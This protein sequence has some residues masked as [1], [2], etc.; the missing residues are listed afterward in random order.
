M[1]LGRAGL[2]GCLARRRIQERR[3]PCHPGFGRADRLSGYRGDHRGD[4]RSEG[5]NPP[6]T[7]GHRARQ[8]YRDG[9]C[10]GG[11]GGGAAARREGARRGRDLQSRLGRPAGADLRACRLGARRG[12][13]GRIGREGHALSPDLPSIDARYRVGQF[14]PAARGRRQ[15]RHESKNVQ[16]VH[17]RDEVRHRD[18]RGMQRHRADAAAGRALVPAV[19]GLRPCEGVQAAGLRRQ[20]CDHRHDRS[21][22][23]AAS[24]Q[25]AGREP[26]AG[27]HLCG[28]QMRAR[29]RA[30][31]CAGIQHPARREFRA[32]GALP[33]DP[34]DRA[35]A[36]HLGRVRG[37]AQG[38]D[39]I[40]DRLP[41]RRGGDREEKHEE[42][43]DARRRGRL[44]RVGQADAGRALAGR[45]HA[46][47]RAR[48]Q[49]QAQARRGG[50]RDAQMGGR[51]V[52]L[53][54]IPP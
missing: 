5:R 14:R 44:L 15:G 1:R 26:P 49:H 40:A 42:G 10:R 46:A 17:R 4:R 29:I 23:V 36:R 11:C 35:R 3:H 38:A 16:L 19:V 20:A 8:A 24:R 34:H 27:R 22:L 47:A 30:A 21:G 51:R 25:V 9:Q 33:A 39:R 2:P 37:A 28:G 53:R 52:R 32:H 54:P 18:D 41:L 13:R 48:A 50:R 31:L 43:R 6:R 7:Q 12:L 45:G